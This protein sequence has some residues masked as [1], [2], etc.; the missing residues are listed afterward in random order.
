MARRF[1]LPGGEVDFDC[2]GGL[3]WNVKEDS[4]PDSA[5]RHEKKPWGCDRK[6]TPGRELPPTRS[7]CV[8]CIEKHLGAACVLMSECRHG[9]PYRLRAIGHLFE[10]EDESQEWPELHAAIRRARKAYQVD[11]TIRHWEA[12]AEAADVVRKAVR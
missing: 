1:F 9:Y 7:S 4:V 8:Q 2:P 12:L 10:A 5:Q 6:A 3:P 11:G